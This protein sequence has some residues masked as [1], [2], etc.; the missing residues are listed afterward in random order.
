WGLTPQPWAAGPVLVHEGSNTRWHA[1]AL[2]D[3]DGGRAMAT[4]SN[5]GPRGRAA[6]VGLAEA[7]RWAYFG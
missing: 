6:C 5:G 2:V 4:I 3:R 1:I 7:L